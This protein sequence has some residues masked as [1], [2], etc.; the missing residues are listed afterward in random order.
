MTTE[1]RLDR[2]DK[3]LNAIMAK[4]QQEHWVTAFVVYQATGWDFNVLKVMKRE[5]VVKW[6]NIKKRYLLES[7][8]KAFL[9]NHQIQSQ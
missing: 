9:K 2:I 5:G 8:P 4:Q 7:I 1:Q 3:K 6:D